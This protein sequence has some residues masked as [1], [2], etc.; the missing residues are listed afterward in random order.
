MSMSSSLLA[1]SKTSFSIRR[2]V[3]TDQF[4]GAKVNHAWTKIGI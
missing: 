3:D 1:E 2:N 4:S